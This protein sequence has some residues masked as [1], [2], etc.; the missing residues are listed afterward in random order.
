MNT[1][2]QLLTL[3]LVLA[4]ATAWAGADIGVV[5]V[6]PAPAPVEQAAAYEVH[7]ANVGNKT[8]DAVTV[9]IELPATHTSPTVHVLGVLSN[10]DPRCQQSGTRLSCSLGR[11]RRG[12][13]TVVGFELALS[14][15]ASPLIV[16]AIGSTTSRDDDGSN[17]S[18]S[19]AITLAHPSLAVSAPTA[20]NVRHCTG[21]GL[22]S[23]FECELFPSSISSHSVTLNLGGSLGFVNYPGYGGTW[24]QPS[25]ERLVMQYTDNGTP[26]ADFDGYANGAGCFEGLT[27]F[28]NSSWV[29]PYEV[30]P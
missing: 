6:T 5:L 7:V 18:A 10:P 3:T 20:A 4:S 16:S 30:C 23:F 13:A 11:L 25:P 21:T 1:H 27:R 8:A 2:T 9:E 24:S 22:T 19:A 28:P 12:R 17:D 26:V 29:S 14:Y 15:S